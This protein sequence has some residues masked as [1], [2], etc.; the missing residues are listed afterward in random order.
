MSPLCVCYQ[1]GSKIDCNP[2]GVCDLCEGQLSR[3]VEVTEQEMC[4]PEENAQTPDDRQVLNILQR[5]HQNILRE[6]EAY[7]SYTKDCRWQFGEGIYRCE[8]VSISEE[9]VT[10]TYHRQMEN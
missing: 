9:D 1:C 8:H 6:S 2:S 4:G 7:V 3:V 10:A 5:L